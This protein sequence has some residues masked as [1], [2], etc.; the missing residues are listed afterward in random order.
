MEINSTF[1][2]QHQNET[3]SEKMFS[4]KIKRHFKQRFENENPSGSK[5]HSLLAFAAALDIVES[6][7]VGNIDVLKN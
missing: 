3:L 4:D 5:I 1:T 7:L 2:F 6:K